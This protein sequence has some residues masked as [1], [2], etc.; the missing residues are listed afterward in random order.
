MMYRND[1]PQI[2]KRQKP[3]VS[4][5]LLLP[6]LFAEPGLQ[7]HIDGKLHHQMFSKLYNS[8]QTI[9]V[10]NSKTLRGT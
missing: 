5:H 10:R 6:S 4:V 8:K 2:I 7:W 9:S 3:K 1:R